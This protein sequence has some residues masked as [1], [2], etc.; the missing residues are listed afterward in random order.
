MCLMLE[1]HVSRGPAMKEEI[2]HRNGR[3]TDGAI[4]RECDVTLVGEARFPFRFP[5]M[6]SLMLISEY[7]LVASCFGCV[8]A[9]V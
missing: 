3:R 6:F 1:N 2:F 7:G 9:G 4:P 5:F 8:E